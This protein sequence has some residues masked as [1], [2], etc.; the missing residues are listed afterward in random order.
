MLRH[1]N[2]IDGHSCD[3]L[4]MPQW[5]DRAQIR[6]L[7]GRCTRGGLVPLRPHTQAQGLLS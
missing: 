6:V 1:S 4:R 3:L 5:C 7:G 2:V